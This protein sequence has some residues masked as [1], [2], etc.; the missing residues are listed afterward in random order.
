MLFKR[1]CKY[2]MK[3]R[4]MCFFVLILVFDT[5]L[6]VNAA[7]NVDIVDS[8]FNAQIQTSVFQQKAVNQ[9]VELSDGKILAAGDFNTY[10]GVPVGALIRLNPDASL[11]T[12]FNNAILEAGSAPQIVTLPNGKILVRGSFTSND[13]TVYAN[14]IIRLNTNGAFDSSF[15]YPYTGNIY[16]IKVD[17][18]GRILVSGI[19]QVTGDDGVVEKNIIRLKDNGTIDLSFNAPS[20]P[21]GP[22]KFTTQ[23]NKILYVRNDAAA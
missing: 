20:I 5:A 3:I 21:N 17:A 14:T 7:Q 18:N 22:N 4:F 19:I 8:T 1:N 23:N 12:T 16:G 15:N 10:N 13:G 11:D 2:M 6:S 9:L